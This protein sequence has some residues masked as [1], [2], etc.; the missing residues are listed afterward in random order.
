M[1]RKLVG[2]VRLGVL[3]FIEDDESLHQLKV[4]LRFEKASELRQ[5]GEN[6]V[7]NAALVRQLHVQIRPFL[8]P[9]LLRL[10]LS[11]QSHRLPLDHL[12]QTVIHLLV[13]R[14]LPDLRVLELVLLL[15]HVKL[16]TF[17]RHCFSFEQASIVFISNVTPFVYNYD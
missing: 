8:L 2:L 12:H 11:R 5:I 13:R 9:L 17:Q 4:L 16:L 1:N 6:S 15:T 7:D 3:F 14:Y 10:L